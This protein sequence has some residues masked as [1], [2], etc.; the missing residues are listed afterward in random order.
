M[1]YQGH[2]AAGAFNNIQAETGSHVLS[3][4]EDSAELRYC[5]L[6]KH[7]MKPSDHDKIPLCKMM[8]FVGGTG[9]AVEWNR[10]ECIINR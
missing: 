7:F 2:T 9:I 3:E 5:H 4:Y 10:W 1:Q 8:Y 6:G